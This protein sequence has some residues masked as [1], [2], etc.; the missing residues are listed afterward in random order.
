MSVLIE[1]KKAGLKFERLEEFEAGIE[2]LGHEVKSL[3]AK[4][5]SL[6]GSRVVIRGGEAY[7]AGATIPAYQPA[8]T[9]KEYEPERSRRLLLSK[10]QI[11]ILG[12]ADAKKGLTI[13]PIEVYNKGNLLKVRVAIVRGKGKADKRE[14]LK[15][16]DAAREADRALKG[17]R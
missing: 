17:G 8:N 7:L 9:D 10:A 6:D 11:R 3:K 14:D 13:V 4:R 2:L 1:Y 5:G 15:K 16:K 12:D